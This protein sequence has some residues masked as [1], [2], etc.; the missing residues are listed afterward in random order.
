MIVR[1]LR[2]SIIGLTLLSIASAGES[3]LS[4]LSTAMSKRTKTPAVLIQTQSM[5]GEQNFKITYKLEMDGSGRYR[6]TVLQPLRMQGVVSVDDGR[7][8]SVF[9]PDDNFVVVQPSPSQCDLRNRLDLIRA[10]YK[11]TFDSPDKVAGRTAFVIRCSAN[12]DGLP[13]RRIYVD[14]ASYL[15]VRMDII[16]DD[17]SA[18]TTIL[19]TL[20]VDL[21]THIAR[22]TFTV[23]TNDSTRISKVDASKTVLNAADASARAGFEV[24]LPKT[25]PFGFSVSR[26]EVL[27]DKPRAMVALRLTDGFVNVTAYQWAPGAEP[28]TRHGSNRSARASGTG[29]EMMAVGDLTGPM[30]QRLVDIISK[31]ALIDWD[32][33]TPY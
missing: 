13:S 17:G 22:E 26:I 14:M 30:L 33:G 11:V 29:F 23:P 18:A 25:L 32:S 10:N 9:Y 6:R 5:P 31:Q 3:A 8:W 2:A 16:P 24:H 27:R 7:Q 19:D 20:S 21:P 1:I 12:S 28:P 15:M 4:V